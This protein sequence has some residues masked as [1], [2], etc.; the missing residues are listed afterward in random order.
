MYVKIS[1]NHI[2]PVRA[3]MEDTEREIEEPKGNSEK[4]EGAM[5]SVVHSGCPR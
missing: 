1:L 2:L 3:K 4:E 5:D